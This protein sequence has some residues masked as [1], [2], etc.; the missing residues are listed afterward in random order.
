MDHFAIKPNAGCIRVMNGTRK[1]LAVKGVIAATL[2]YLC[3]MVT[4]SWGQDAIKYYNLGL[5]SSLASEKIEYFSKALELNPTLAEAYEKRGIH[6]FFKGQL[7]DAIQDYT[8]AIRLKPHNAANYQMRG[9]AYFKKAHGEGLMAEINRLALKYTN[10]GVPESTEILSMAIDD[11]SS[12]IE[13]NPQLVSAYSYRAEAYRLRGRISEAMRDCT[14]A[15]ELQGDSRTAAR[16]YATRAKIYRKLGNRELSEADY[17]RSVV[18]DPYSPDYPPLHVPLM[19][20]YSANTAGLKTVGRLGLIILLVL[21]CVVIFR[22]N[23]HAPKK[24]D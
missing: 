21:T 17:R 15:I 22:L 1:N 20:G 3:L 18:L 19:L 13:L 7:E 12:A 11:F 9:V 8:R 2:G 24:R 4:P 16:A 10:L 5:K 14:T 23:L 6:Y